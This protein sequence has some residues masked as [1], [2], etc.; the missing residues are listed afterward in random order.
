MKKNKNRNLCILFVIG[1]IIS[2]VFF[3]LKFNND[4]E[5]KLDIAG[6]NVT[7]FIHR[8]DDNEIDFAKRNVYLYT[9][10]LECG[11][12]QKN[13]DFEIEL[14]E[15]P[16]KKITE[17]SNNNILEDIFSKSVDVSDNK[18]YRHY[19]IEYNSDNIVKPKNIKINGTKKQ[20]DAVVEY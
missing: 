12:S 6:F 19:L 10:V 2:F 9:L 3:H 17:E 5:D 1:V 15:M 8:I 4:N 16:G 11:Y 18:I 14:D 7:L 13:D 20:I